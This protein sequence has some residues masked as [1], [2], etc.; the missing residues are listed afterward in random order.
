MDIQELNRAFRLL[1]TEGKGFITKD[2]LMR[3]VG[4]D[5]TDYTDGTAAG[6]I[7]MESSGSAMALTG[8][9]SLHSD[10]FDRYDSRCRCDSK[11][12]DRWKK[13]AEKMS[14][15]IDKADVNKDGVVSYA[16]FLFA[17]ADGQ[18]PQELR[19]CTEDSLTQ[20]SA[21]HRS[22]SVIREEDE[23]DLALKAIKDARSD[24]ITSAFRRRKSDSKLNLVDYSNQLQGVQKALHTPLSSPSRPSLRSNQS[25]KSF[26]KFNSFFR[27][28][29]V[30]FCKLPAMSTAL[31]EQVINK[32]LGGKGKG[33]IYA[34][35]ESD[36]SS[37]EAE[38]S[39]LSPSAA[40]LTL[41]RSLSSPALLPLDSPSARQLEETQKQL[42]VTSVSEECVVEAVSDANSK[43]N[44]SNAKTNFS[45]ASSP[46]SGH[47]SFMG[48]LI[49]KAAG[50]FASVSPFGHD[51]LS[52]HSIGLSK[53]DTDKVGELVHELRK[54][55]AR[56][57][58]ESESTL[59]SQEDRDGK[60]D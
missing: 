22:A 28:I 37:K 39:L 2:D 23:L 40:K 38:E 35:D 51:E 1:D 26:F 24:K 55:F 5:Y 52:A 8:N 30:L 15:I 49:E 21:L 54:N 41:N 42:E 53:S 25:P 48:S 16:E 59:L 4:H 60:G 11:E 32:P 18:E 57:L 50:M 9:A 19:Q 17:M 3:V 44:E 58:E 33:K 7:V 20:S 47:K 46:S 43:L 6:T 34:L 36:F 45:E 31:V 13:L 12:E 14:N 56:T 27:N 10:S 29:S